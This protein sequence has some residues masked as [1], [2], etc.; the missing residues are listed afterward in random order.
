[1]GSYPMR[2]GVHDYDATSTTESRD[3][4]KFADQGL[5]AGV[6]NGLSEVTAIKR[7]NKEPEQEANNLVFRREET[8]EDAGSKLGK[9]FTFR[10]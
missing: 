3:D 2:D 7:G 1:M 6:E 10:A 9:N 5:K 8:E 4:R